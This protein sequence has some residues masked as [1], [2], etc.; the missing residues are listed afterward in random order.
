MSKKAKLLEIVKEGY[1][2]FNETDNFEIEFEGGGDNFGSFYGIE[3]T[4]VV[5]TNLNSK[6][7]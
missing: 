3:S 2:D 7:N 4:E 6:V 1:P 5:I